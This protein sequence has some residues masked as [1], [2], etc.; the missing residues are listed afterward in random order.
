[1]SVRITAL[2]A[3]LVAALTLAECGGGG[4][5]VVLQVGPASSG[6]STTNNTFHCDQQITADQPPAQECDNV[7]QAYARNHAIV[8]QTIISNGGP[9]QDATQRAHLKQ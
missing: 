3:L 1:M 9:V 7:L 5:C 8:H 6:G 4:A 2:L